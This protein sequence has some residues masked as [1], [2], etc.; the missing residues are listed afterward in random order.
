MN[1]RRP[2]NKSLK[3][4][5]STIIDLEENVRSY[6]AKTGFDVHVGGKLTGHGSN[7]SHIV[8]IVWV[9]CGR[10][11]MYY[12]SEELASMHYFFT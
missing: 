11:F 4:V 5:L 2:H 8:S 6:L 12:L 9:E 10:A 1:F 7:C 3:S